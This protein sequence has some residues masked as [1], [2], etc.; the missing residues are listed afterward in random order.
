ML[1]C[2]IVKET[3]CMAVFLLKLA[4]IKGL[5]NIF[6]L[7]SQSRHK[8]KQKNQKFIKCEMIHIFLVYFIYILKKFQT[9]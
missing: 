5:K 7:Q 1:V 2:Y 3:I 8:S 6:D 4:H 9:L